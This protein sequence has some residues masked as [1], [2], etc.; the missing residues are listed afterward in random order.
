MDAKQAALE[1]EFAK[2]LSRA[3]EIGAQ[4]QAIE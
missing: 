3:A 4:I 2:V 1:K